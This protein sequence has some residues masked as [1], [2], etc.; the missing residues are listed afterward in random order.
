MQALKV[1][2]PLTGFIAPKYLQP[3]AQRNPVALKGAT[4]KVPQIIV[5]RV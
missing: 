4:R 1:F 3:F 5:P 2:A